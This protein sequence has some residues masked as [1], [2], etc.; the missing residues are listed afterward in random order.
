MPVL[1]SSSKLDPSGLHS[2]TCPGQTRG[3]HDIVERALKQEL[4]PSGLMVDNQPTWTAHKH[5]PD[6]QIVA[7]THP[8]VICAEGH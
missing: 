6:L 3:H 4:N 7:L 5:I 2:H 1:S 8:G